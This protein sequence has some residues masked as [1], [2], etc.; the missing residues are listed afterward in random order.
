MSKLLA[1]TCRMVERVECPYCKIGPRMR[2]ITR[3]GAMR[4]KPHADRFWWSNLTPEGR[5]EMG[6]DGKR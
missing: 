6:K 3:K 5:L 4:S 2:C 1:S